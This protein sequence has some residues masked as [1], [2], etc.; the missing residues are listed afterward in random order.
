MAEIT[1]FATE[2]DCNTIWRIIFGVGMTAYPSSMFGSLPSPALIRQEDVTE[3]LSQYPRIAPAL[4]YFLTAPDWTHRPL[5]YRPCRDNP[6]FD[7]HWNVRQR[8]GGPSIH[9]IPRFG[10][11]RK[12]ESE[13]I[14]SG[15]FGDYPS[16]YCTD[17]PDQIVAR[18]PGLA[19]AMGE[20]RRELRSQGRLVRSSTGQR[21]I[22]LDGAVAA[23]ESGVVL[24]CGNIV[25]S[26]ALRSGRAVN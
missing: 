17:D 18:P 1:F 11:P 24:R 2:D 7:P 3:H 4:S 5:E 13:Q 6:H 26:P 12:Q 23:H 10:Y 19:A 15:M 22:A 16:Y 14:V 9:F 21:T 25:Y 8:Y 20:I